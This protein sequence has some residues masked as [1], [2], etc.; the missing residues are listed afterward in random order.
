VIFV[1]C[2]IVS[3]VVL[4]TILCIAVTNIMNI[5]STV[6]GLLCRHATKTQLIEVN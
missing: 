6:G 3:P 2:S 1:D 4:N 5:L